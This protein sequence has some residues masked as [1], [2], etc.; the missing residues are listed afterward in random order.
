[1]PTERAPLSPMCANASANARASA[2]TL[3]TLLSTHTSKQPSTSAFNGSTPLPL[4]RIQRP[5]EGS[6]GLDGLGR[7]WL[8]NARLLALKRQQLRLRRKV[9]CEIHDR[10]SKNRIEY[11]TAFRNTLWAHWF[12]SK[13]KRPPLDPGSFLSINC[14]RLLLPCKSYMRP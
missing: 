8:G 9:C 7:C 10:F 1:M 2:L 14:C 11:A 3:G 5:S 12:L 13:R 6:G 4:L